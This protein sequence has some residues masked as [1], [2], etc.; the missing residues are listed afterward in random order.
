LELS[1]PALLERSISQPEG[2]RDLGTFKSDVHVL[3]YGK[4][5]CLTKMLEELRCGVAHPL[6]FSYVRSSW[7]CHDL[8]PPQCLRQWCSGVNFDLLPSL[9]P[10]PHFQL[11]PWAK[12]LG[13]HL[14]EVSSPCLRL[15]KPWCYQNLRS[16]PDRNSSKQNTMRK[17]Y[18]DLGDSRGVI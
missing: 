9:L 15:K 18:T 17:W 7:T 5:C 10:R 3:E 8:S 13:G 14:L 16:T 12:N 6:R 2:N 4:G 11:L 1:F